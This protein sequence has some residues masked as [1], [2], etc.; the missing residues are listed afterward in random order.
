MSDL[1]AEIKAVEQQAK[2]S[3]GIVADAIQKQQA[4]DRSLIA[5]IVIFTF[6]GLVVAVTLAALAGAYLFNWDTL[7]EPGKYVMTLLSSVMLP[8]VTLVIGYYFSNK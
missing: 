7:V 6:L 1:D 2:G 5:R 4:D 8:I 3:V